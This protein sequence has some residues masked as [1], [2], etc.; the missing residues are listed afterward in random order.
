MTTTPENQSRSWHDLAD[1]LTP[2]QIAELW[3]LERDPAN[4]VRITGNSD[5]LW[6]IDGLR[7]YARGCARDNLVAAMV[8]EVPLPAAGDETDLRA[9]TWQEHAPLPYRSFSDDGGV[10]DGGFEGPAVHIRGI[11]YTRQQA[12]QFAAAVFDAT[13]RLDQFAEAGTQ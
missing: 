5:L 12:R 13:D 11:A 9:E 8:G 10:D 2:E 1:Q 6:D 7:C 4:L 3:K